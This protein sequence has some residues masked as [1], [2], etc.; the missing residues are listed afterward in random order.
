[1]GDYYQ[2]LKENRFQIHPSR[3]AMAGL[4]GM[5]TVVNSGLAV[6]QRLAFGKKIANAN[7]AG[8]PVFIIG[9]WRSG[10]TL[11][12][13]LI[14]LDERFN[15]PSNFE[16]F[17]PAHFL[18]SR[19]IVYP[20][21]RLLM[22]ARR[23]MDNMSM[24]AGSPQ[25]D[26]FALIGLGAPTP[27]RRIAFANRVGRDHLEL[28]F[29]LAKP[30][31]EQKLREAMETFVKSLAIRYQSQLVMK[32][33][34]HTGRIAQLAKWFPDAK[35]IHLSRHPYKLVPSTMRLWKLLDKLQ[36]F[37]VPKYD[38]T[39]LKNYI[40]ECKDLMYESYFEHREQLPANRLVEIRFEDLVDQPIDQLRRAYDQLELGGFEDAKP[41]V[42]DY[43][44]RKKSH[45]KNELQLDEKLKLEI[46]S[47]WQEYM[48]KFGY[49]PN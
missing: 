20:L 49:E 28:N 12:H 33:P 4:V 3:Y 14:S 13:E 21:I 22:P 46:D 32:S 45:K 16:A 10:T 41:N 29:D 6:A 47:N 17:V 24:G 31:T 39:W 43:F 19:P 11:M 8:P 2:L 9:H 48:A 18:V 27:Y 38:D 40:F 37:Q 15:F 34:P 23:P 35:F 7:L 1:M 30:V 36:S 25:E 26:D 44:E 5:C 42:Q